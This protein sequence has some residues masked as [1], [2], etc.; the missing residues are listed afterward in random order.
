MATKTA[1]QIARDLRDEAERL[2][3]IALV[4]EGKR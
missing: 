4:L 2:I 3:H 1:T